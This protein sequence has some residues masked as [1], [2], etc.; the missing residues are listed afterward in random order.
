MATGSGSYNGLAVPLSGESEIVQVNAGTDVLTITS[1]ADATAA[2]H[3]RVNVTSTSA[4]TAGYTQ[5]VYVN[6]NIDGGITG[7]N[8]I[9]ANAFAADI[10]YDSTNSGFIGGAYMYFAEGSTGAT[11]TGSTLAGYTAW[12][13]ASGSA[14]DYRAG[15]WAG[16]EETSSYPG[17]SADSAFL[18]ECAS[19]SAWGSLL[20]AHG[21]PPTY[22]LHQTTALVAGTMFDSD[23]TFSATPTGGLKCNMHG[24]AYYIALYQSCAS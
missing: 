13:A 20:C 4:I 22:F 7:G 11:M 16:S 17:A 18:A 14:T 6:M 8:T 23:V 2:N 24:T 5:G 1:V 10:T 21:G 3:I 9:Q 12:F 19:S 15:F